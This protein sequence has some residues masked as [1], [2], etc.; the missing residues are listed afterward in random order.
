MSVE[1]WALIHDVVSDLVN[2][3]EDSLDTIL[4]Q[5]GTRSFDKNHSSLDAEVAFNRNVVS[6]LDLLLTG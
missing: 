3:Q 4:L 6:N 5:T 1:S 2:R